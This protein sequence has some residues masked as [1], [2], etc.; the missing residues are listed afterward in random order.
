[1]FV[2]IKTT[3][4][5]PKKAVQIVES[6]RRGKKISQKI[7]R[8]LGY[9]LDEDELVKLKLLAE[10]IIIR[11]EAGS[12]QLLF[13]P[14]EL[15]KLKINT[16]TKDS[17]NEYKVNLK[18]LVEED[19]TISGIHDV[20]GSLFNQLGY[21]DIFKNPAQQK[22]YGDIYKHIVLARIANPL[23]KMASVDM[24]EENFGI[25]LDLHK[26]YQMMDNLDDPTIERLN[27]ITYQNTSNLY[28]G[29]I[30]VIFFDATTVYFESFS[31]D[32][33]K[34]IGFSKDLKFNQ[35]QV[36]LSL[37]VS[38]DGLAIGYKV[39][40]GSVYEGHTL[41][42]ALKDLRQSYQIDKVIF[43][44][45]AGMFNQNNLKELDAE[46]FEYI[47]GARLK[48]LSENLKEKILDKKCYQG[49]D[50][51][52]IAQFEYEA[53]KRLVVS[54]KENRA[55]KDALERTKAIEKLKL[56]LEKQK[57][58]KGYLSNCSYKKY[59]KVTGS[60]SIEL[61]ENKIKEASLWDGLHGVIT[62]AKD[63][64]NEQILKQY[65]HLWHVEEA[66]RITKHDLKVRPI[67]HWTEKRI[68]AHLAICFTAYALVRYLEY[69]VR[70][71][72]KNLSIEKIRQSLIR[73][74]TSILYHTKKKIKFAL[75][76]R[77]SQEAKKIYQI[78]NLTRSLTP[79]LIK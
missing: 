60:S 77:I 4:N 1:M 68:K 5:T 33:F 26:V 12:Q 13:S 41:I 16:A 69:R 28:G 32:E 53:E 70:L 37:M 66:F 46:G 8:H 10:S 21:Q 74:Q 64:T 47:V 52:N 54:Y 34:N 44:A 43:V 72:Y 65:V 27:K 22:T 38:K 15:A 59:L 24:L 51:F 45:D 2:R 79:W 19:R 17:D 7:I 42:P 25:S 39:F 35:P 56:K 78:M 62:N 61:D 58:P 29:K 67:F 36:L 73:V 49:N 40:P 57:N 31:N 18:D 11:M 23:S 14:E 71:Q 55:R 30:D 76:S 75:P 6:V 48:N 3:P 20:Y 50:D 63:I 9:A